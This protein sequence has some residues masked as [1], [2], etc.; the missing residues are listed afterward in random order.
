MDEENCKKC[1]LKRFMLSMRYPDCVFA[2]TSG[3][4]H[5]SKCIVS[6]GAESRGSLR[7]GRTGTLGVLSIATSV[8]AGTEGDFVVGVKYSGGKTERKCQELVYRQEHPM[9]LEPTEI[10]N[11]CYIE[12]LAY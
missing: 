7:R 9:L 5:L 1:F 4:R 10:G 2:T 3:T 6:T 12:E 8:L 11:A